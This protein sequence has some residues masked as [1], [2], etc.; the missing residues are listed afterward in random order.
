LIY[1]TVDLISKKKGGE[2]SVLYASL[3]LNTCGLI[4]ALNQWIKSLSVD[5]PCI[6]LIYLEKGKIPRK[7]NKDPK[8]RTAICHPGDEHD[9]DPKIRRTPAY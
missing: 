8:P 1:V 3:M 4:L 9:H 2:K 5:K 6:V 7:M